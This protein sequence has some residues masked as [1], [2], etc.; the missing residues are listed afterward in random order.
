MSCALAALGGARRHAPGATPAYQTHLAVAAREPWRLVRLMPLLHSLSVLFLPV[1]VIELLKFPPPTIYPLRLLYLAT[2][3]P[4]TALQLPH[5]LRN[6]EWARQEHDCWPALPW[7]PSCSSRRRRRAGWPGTR[8]RCG[9]AAGAASSSRRRCS[10]RTRRARRRSSGSSWSGCGTWAGSGTARS[11]TRSP[12]RP[13]PTRSWWTRT[14]RS[15]TSRPSRPPSTRSRP[16]TSSASSS[17]S[18]PAPTR[19]HA[20]VPALR[21]A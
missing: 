3:T 9:P 10:R 6:P 5:S 1:T 21:L 7:R 13:P 20:G 18:T 14:P 8:G 11:S 16:S 2:P 17:G 4:A 15:A 19:T 12:A